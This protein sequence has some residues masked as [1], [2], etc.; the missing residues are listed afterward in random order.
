MI[1][2]RIDDKRGQSVRIV[3]ECRARGGARRAG[4]NLPQ[5][6]GLGERPRA[7]SFP[8]R[9]WS[10]TT[11]PGSSCVWRA[12]R[13]GCCARCS[14]RRCCS[15]PGTSCACIDPRIDVEKFL[16]QHRIAEVGR[17]AVVPEHRG[18]LMLAAALMR[19]ATEEM[20][21]RGYTHV[22]HRRVRG[23]SAQ[24]AR[25]P[26]AGDGLRAGGHPRPRR[27]QLQEPAHHAAA[28]P[29]GELPAPQ[30][31][32]QLDL[33]L[34]DGALARR[35]AP[36]LCDLSAAAGP[37]R[38]A[39]CPWLPLAA[40]W[41]R[42]SRCLL[43]RSQDRPARVDEACRRPEKRSCQEEQ[44]GRP[45]SHGPVFP[46]LGDR[47]G[48]RRPGAGHRDVPASV[49]RRQGAATSFSPRRPRAIRARPAGALPL[50][51]RLGP[52]ALV[53]LICRHPWC[54]GTALTHAVCYGAPA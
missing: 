7:A 39:V 45:R 10:G 6:E 36:A 19:S 2:D 40:G 32:R 50:V 24:P 27:A 12:G 54:E 16:R 17:F 44:Y 11:S 23:R 20:V 38:A 35:P 41:T 26:Y 37:V 47:R 3:D 1:D 13:S 42:L 15:T 46:C 51:S 8:R 49:G 4:R 53:P 5:R 9:T 43:L 25:L 28:R 22:D 31:T 30:G 48:D 18:N 34:S 29:G 52:C 14:T 21:T 33:P